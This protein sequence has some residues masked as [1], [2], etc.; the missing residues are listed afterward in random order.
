MPSASRLAPFYELLDMPLATYKNLAASYG[1]TDL[2]GARC[3][4]F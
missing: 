3:R 2:R 4:Q 1:T